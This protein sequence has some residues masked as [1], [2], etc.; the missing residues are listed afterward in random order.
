MPIERADRLVINESFLAKNVSDVLLKYRAEIID[1]LRKNLI[2]SDKDQPGKLIQSI[3][4]KILQEGD[5]LTF[6]L[7]MEDYYKFIDEGVSG[8]DKQNS[9][10]YKFKNNGKPANIG[11]MLNF[12]RARGIKQYKKPNGEII[13]DANI[14]VKKKNQIKLIKN[15]QVKKSFKQVTA[16][17][18]LKTLAYLIGM[19]IKRVGIKPTYFFSNVI[20]DELYTK[21]KLDITKAIGRDIE[22][23]FSE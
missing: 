22:I 21:M 8:W 17:K 18:R 3:D 12:I 7:L 13:Y 4:V 5:N 14:G 10:Q 23:S 16:E 20:N 6:R 9:S 11:A 2:E 15:K 19:R 1:S